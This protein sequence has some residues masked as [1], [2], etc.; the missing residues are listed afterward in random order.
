MSTDS[1]IS[2]SEKFCRRHQRTA[3]LSPNRPDSARERL[4]VRPPALAWLVP[5][6][7]EPAVRFVPSELLVPAPVPVAPP[8]AVPVAVAPEDDEVDEADV[9]VPVAVAPAADDAVAF[10]F[11]LEE[12]VSLEALASSE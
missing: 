12:P 6:S 1:Q 3:A 8:D 11:D 9:D 10:V 5:P 4:P 2:G 7:V